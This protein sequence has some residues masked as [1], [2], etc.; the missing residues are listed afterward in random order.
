M[1]F[2]LPKKKYVILRTKL[3]QAKTKMMKMINKMHVEYFSN[4][5]S[6]KNLKIIWG[7]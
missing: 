6:L 5:L 1:G 7:V 2:F 3:I 4:I